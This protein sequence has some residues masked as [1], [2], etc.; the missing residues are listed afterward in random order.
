MLLDFVLCIYILTL[1]Y[2]KLENYNSRKALKTA[3]YNDYKEMY[4]FLLLYSKLVITCGIYD[5]TYI[6][7]GIEH[8][9]E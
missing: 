4:I 2:P 6:V 5:L 8:E 3:E 9:F 1:Q 7:S